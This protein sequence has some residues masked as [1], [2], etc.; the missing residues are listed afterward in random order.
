MSATNTIERY[1]V[2]CESYRS[3]QLEEREETHAIRGIEITATI[4]HF[5][6]PICE[7]EISD[8]HADPMVPLYAA[9]RDTKGLLQP[10]D[11]KRIREKYH[12]SHE[13]FAKLLGMSPATLYRYEGGAIQDDAHDLLL[14]AYAD[15][16]KMKEL[17]ERR[18][19]LLSSSQYRK[20]LKAI[21]GP[22]TTRLRRWGEITHRSYKLLSVGS[23]QFVPT[24][25]SE[26]ILT[27]EST[28]GEEKIRTFSTSE[29]GR[30]SC[31]FA[32]QS[33]IDVQ[34]EHFHHVG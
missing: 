23:L 25:S 19:S 2:K 13:A 32:R 27:L 31:S 15:T 14:R 9:Y 30:Q 16:D 24:E 11:I 17:F 18:G 5:V 10:H 34:S 28:H 12:L 33:R 22:W 29:T 21:A 26:L 3:F 1:C 4:P 6:C 20:F 8:P 7:S